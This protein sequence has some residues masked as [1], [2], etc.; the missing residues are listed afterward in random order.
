MNRNQKSALIVGML[1]VVL[2][3]FL[4]WGCDPGDSYTPEVT[5][6]TPVDPEVFFPPEDTDR[7]NDEVSIAECLTAR[8][9]VLYGASWC[10]W[11]KKQIES[12]GESFRHIVYVE[13]TANSEKCDAAGIG[14]YPTWII[15]GKR[16]SG[17][18]PPEALADLAGC[19]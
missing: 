7:S 10:S 6:G 1:L 3:A 16:Y 13:C 19:G 4:V 18:R 8:G 17:F 11:T 2:L 5:Y 15:K 14:S 12:F 9:A